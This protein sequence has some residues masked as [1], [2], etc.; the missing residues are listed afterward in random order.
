MLKDWC[1]IFL[2][3]PVLLKEQQESGHSVNDFP[4]HA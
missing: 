4:I 2:N 1:Y 3:D